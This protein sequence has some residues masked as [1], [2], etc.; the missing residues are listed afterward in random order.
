MSTTAIELSSQGSKALRVIFWAGLIAGTLDLTGACLVSWLRA[1]VTP[2]RVFQSVASGLYGAASF[3]GGAKTAVLGVV[4]H[5][6]IATTWAVVYYLA[7]RQL[8]FLIDHTIIAGVLYGVLVYLFMNFVVLPLSAVPR[9]PVPLSGRLIGMSI[10][11]L[12][13]GLPI[14]AIVR[15]FSK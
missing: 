15:R 4:L 12:C 6:I 9:R 13:I 7:S 5:F 11:I 2:V 1:G 10:I 8:R 3:T 14:A